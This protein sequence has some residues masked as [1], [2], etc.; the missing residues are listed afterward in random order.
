MNRSTN[1]APDSL[2][3]SYLMGSAF[4][5][6]SITTL[7]SSGRLRPDGT[8]S[9]LMAVPCERRVSGDRARGGG[10]A[11]DD[12][13]RALLY[14]G[15]GVLRELGKSQRRFAKVH[16]R[17]GSLVGQLGQSRQRKRGGGM[18]AQAQAFEQIRA[19]L[20]PQ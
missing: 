18:H 2:S 4:I 7:K 20:A 8:R 12:A 5:G 13:R 15:A 11:R 3:T 9:R 14:L 19:R 10:V 6:I 1:S 17:L 16:R